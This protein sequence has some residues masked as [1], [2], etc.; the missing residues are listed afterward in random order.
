[1]RVRCDDQV[2]KTAIIIPTFK[3]P[4]MVERL[5]NNLARSAMPVGARVM[6]VEN[7]PKCGVEAICRQAVWQGSV[8]YLYVE[9]G[10]RSLALNH[11]IEHSDADLLIFFDDDIGIPEDIGQTYVEA[12]LRYGPGHFFGGPLIADAETACPAHLTPYLPASAKGWRPADDEMEMDPKGY[13]YFFGANWAVFRADL[14]KVGAFSELLGVGAAKNSPL[15][16]ETELQQRLFDAGLKGIYLPSAVIEHPVPKECY[17]LDWVWRRKFRQ[18]LT[19]WKMGERFGTDHRWRV[20]GVPAWIIRA[21]A[22]QKIKVAI[23]SLFRFA[24]AERTRIKM[25]EAYLAGVFYGAWTGRR[26]PALTSGRS[27]IDR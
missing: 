8:Q 17:T 26:D 14:A 2:M 9:T 16:E 13:V 20:L 7:G 19:E 25:Q 15:G 1:M 12:A 24:I 10:S 27:G 18:G 11:A 4:Q 23:A 21:L 22:E 6:V 3:R 5:L